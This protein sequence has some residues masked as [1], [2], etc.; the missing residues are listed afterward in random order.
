MSKFS[1]TIHEHIKRDKRAFTVYIVLRTIVIV[2][3]VRAAMRQEYESVFVCALSL[4]LLTMP[5]VVERKLNIDLPTTLE[6]IVMVFIFA[7]EIL[8]EIGEYYV[9]FEYW[10]TILHT[11]NGFLCAAIG[12]SL[13]DL[14]NR[15][16]RTALRLS[17]LYMSIAAFCFSMTVGVLWEFFEFGADCLVH[18]DMQKDTVISAIHSVALNPT[19]ANK[20]VG[21]ENITSVVVNGEELG[22][23]GYLDIGLF[24][25]MEDM[26]VNFV[27]AVVFSVIGFFYVKN[28][29][30]GRFAKRF[31]PVVLDE[32]EDAPE[33]EK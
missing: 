19:G 15:S 8:G 27:G 16:E 9:K 13:V 29:G 26:F 33:K 1:K 17:P 25:T 22:L 23:G 2:T 12:F 21:I 18:T 14:L 30:R 31:I 32:P 10:D 5:A 20:P 3:L 24:D 6:I 28:R 7:A 11:T 4:F